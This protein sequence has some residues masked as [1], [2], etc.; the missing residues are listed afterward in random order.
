M[1][2]Y[3][4]HLYRQQGL[5]LNFNILR[6]FCNNVMKH[7]R[8][9]PRQCCDLLRRITEE[10]LDPEGMC[11]QAAHWY[12]PNWYI[13][14]RPGLE[15][16]TLELLTQISI[17]PLHE[18]VI[19]SYDDRKEALSKRREYNGKPDA[20]IPTIYIPRITRGGDVFFQGYSSPPRIIHLK[21]KSFPQTITDSPHFQR[22]M[23]IVSSED[24][25]LYPAETDPS[26]KSNWVYYIVMFDPTVSPEAAK[27]GYIG[28]TTQP[29]KTRMRQHAKSSE[30]MIIHYNLALISQYA[31]Q[32]GEDLS[33]YVAV[34]ALGTTHDHTSCKV[35]EGV[36]IRESL[37]GC[38]VTNMKY[39]MNNKQSAKKHDEEKISQVQNFPKGFNLPLPP[40]LPSS[41][42]P[43]PHTR[44]LLPSLTP[45]RWHACTPTLIGSRSAPSS[46][47]T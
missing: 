41:S 31:Q 27:Q 45:A 36:L 4:Q 29:L 10:A 26:E 2:V 3:G 39:G 13:Q 34:F 42:S 11:F 23:N 47:E 7:F 9:E 1:G 20:L 6:T 37:E 17:W 14:D 24:Y 12:A 46:N 18:P 5:I 16:Y 44:T 30:D 15:G 25:C 22:V 38:S 28:M 19:T 43:A 33:K 8:L 40:P 21:P 32:R 35:L